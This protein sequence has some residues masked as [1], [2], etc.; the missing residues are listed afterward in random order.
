MRR[1]LGKDSGKTNVHSE[2]RSPGLEEVEAKKKC[3]RDEEA[4]G[5]SSRYRG[6]ERRQHP[7]KQ[8]VS[9]NGHAALVS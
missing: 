6:R 4:F 3:A 9:E 8:G 2:D 7:S 1:Q 5:C